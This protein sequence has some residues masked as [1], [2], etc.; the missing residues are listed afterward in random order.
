MGFK[1]TKFVMA[2]SRLISAELTVATL[3][4]VGSMLLSRRVSDP[5]VHKPN[6][7]D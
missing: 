2:F 3:N 6:Y 7:L 4:L 1:L 5:V